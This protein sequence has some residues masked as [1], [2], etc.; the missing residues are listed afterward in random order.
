[1]LRLS[2]ELGTNGQEDEMKSEKNHFSLW[3]PEDTPFH[4]WNMHQ[5]L[6]KMQGPHEGKSGSGV[7]EA[8]SALAQEP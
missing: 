1:M 4:S 5:L 3:L 2:G 7:Q 8:A 6:M